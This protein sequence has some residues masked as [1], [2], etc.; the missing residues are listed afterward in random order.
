M[1]DTVRDIRLASSESSRPQSES[2][3]VAGKL[4]KYNVATE[5]GRAAL[6][7]LRPRLAEQVG[8]A[9]SENKPHAPARTRHRRAS[10]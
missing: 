5:L 2:E 10:R 9:L 1:T 3:V 4:R 8:E 6:S 7:E